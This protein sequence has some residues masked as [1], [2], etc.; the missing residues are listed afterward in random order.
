MLLRYGRFV[1]R[2]ARFVLAGAVI[3]LAVFIALGASVFSRLESAGFND[4]AS[5]SSHAA[6]LLSANFPGQ[7]NVVLL[8]TPRT[9]QGD[10]QSPSVTA[11][12]LDLA[13]QLQH[14]K[15]VTAVASWWS[16]HAPE[17]RSNDGR[18]ALIVAHVNA[19]G[20]TTAQD[21]AKTIISKF[22]T[23]TAVLNVTVGGPLAA[24]VD[25]GT[26][27][28]KDLGKAEGIAVPLTLIL[29]ILAF[30]S[31]VAAP[32]P[33]AVGVFAIFGT[34]AELFVISQFTD[35]SIFAINLATAMGLGLGIDYAL[36]IVSR[37]REELTG[38]STEE[39]L[40]ATITSA[41]R[42]IIFSSLTVAVAL[43]ALL[44]FPLYFLRSFAYAGI[45]VVIIA[46]L[47]ALFILPAILALLGPK[48]NAARI[49]RNRPLRSASEASRFWGGLATRVMRHPIVFALP[50]I[51]LLLLAGSPFLHASFGIPD[52]RV[53]PTS[54]ASRQVGDALRSNFPN[55]S[56]TAIVAVIDGQTSQVQTVAY[57]ER[58]STLS[59]V[60]RVSSTEG[61]FVGG[62]QVAPANP[63]DSQYGT[64]NLQYLS[65]VGPVDTQSQ[66]SQ[67]LVGAI[68][69][70]PAP[71]NAA[72]YVG[73]PAAELVD[74]N[75]AI[76]GK[77]P[78]ALAL[79]AVTTFILLFLFTG[80]V[81]LPLKALVLNLLSLTAVFGAMVWI[82]QDGHGS[83]LLGFTPGLVN[84]S[85][86]VLLFC[87]AFGLSMDYE[88]FLLSRIKEFRDQGSSNTDA[89]IKGVAHTGRIITTA[90]AL[91]SVTFLAFIVSQVSFMQLF[92]LGTAI[93]IVADATLIR[94]VLVPAFMRL[95]GSANWWAPPFLRRVHQRFGISDAT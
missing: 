22:G 34:F 56:S 23:G 50:V 40:I 16:T 3:I 82:F 9:G 55:G 87:V 18:Q 11:A 95:A 39:A 70:L 83:S 49:F 67:N 94:G 28:S 41:G 72:A 51:T 35:V 66:A 74:G 53:L 59:S 57:A 91:L 63:S 31:L 29:L 73:G 14:Q 43:S 69:A 19:T 26:Q 65:I 80:S 20:S 1:L 84:T 32:L 88:V 6:A 21:N 48:V 52:D 45:G 17:M 92:G 36:L 90:A 81:V 89:V 37:F 54:S 71:A 15:G 79:I 47:S 60:S 38:K 12:A 5:G 42:T 44:V 25:T 78:L 76:A 77:L 58:I 27:V 8:V 85:M 13:Q 93:A 68:R 61:V 30:G 64:S 75:D 62:R 10:L 4:P 33:L 2:R 7:P 46:L 86:P 24:G